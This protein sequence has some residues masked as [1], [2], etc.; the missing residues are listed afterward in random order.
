MK[1]LLNKKWCGIRI[2]YFFI[3]VLLAVFGIIVGSFFDLNVS[4]TLYD[5]NSGF[6]Q[7]YETFGTGLGY[8]MIPSSAMMLFLA[9][10]KNKNK[11]L[12]ILAYF[13]LIA[14]ALITT[15]IYGHSLCD[16]QEYGLTTDDFSAYTF[17]FSL[18]ALSSF[19]TFLFVDKKDKRGLILVGSVVLFS[20]A[21]QLALINFLLKYLA[22][23]PRYRF[24]MGD[25]NP[26]ALDGVSETFR[27]WW[28]MKP[29]SH[30]SGDY[31]KSWPSGHTS[32]AAIALTLVLYPQVAEKKYK[33]EELIF[34]AVGFCHLI[35]TAFAR[36]V[37]GA[38]YLTDVS[39]ATLFSVSGILLSLYLVD[40]FSQKF[41]IQQLANAK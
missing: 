11:W 5:K 21:I 34:F 1:Q 3:V 10:Y 19:L 4:K 2:S 17:A 36:I 27:A 15:Y 41:P 7:F 12:K 23:R 38:H 6:G 32:T 31:Y 37:A 30:M 29:F 14:S 22:M 35:L 25:G 33:C 13:L 40:L 9:L 16:N 26:E 20:M 28:E 8:M 39:F 18:M 24:L